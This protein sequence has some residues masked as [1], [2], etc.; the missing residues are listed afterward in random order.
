MYNNS[1]DGS[2][3][4]VGKSTNPFDSFSDDDDSCV[5]QEC[6]ETEASE[7]AEEESL[8]SE[9]TTSTFLESALFD[10][11]SQTRSIGTHKSDFS[12]KRVAPLDFDNAM[13]NQVLERPALDF[14]SA[15]HSLHASD[16]ISPLETAMT[17]QVEHLKSAVDN[18]DSGGEEC[19]EDDEAKKLVPNPSTEKS[20][21]DGGYLSRLR[22]I[23][24]YFGAS[25]TQDNSDNNTVNK[26]NLIMEG[27]H[28]NE[29]ASP[30]RALSNAEAN[31]F[32]C[33]KFP[34][35]PSEQL[36]P[37]L[38]IP[39]NINNANKEET[40]L[41]EVE[42]VL[43]R[44]NIVEEALKEN[45]NKRTLKARHRKIEGLQD[46]R[47]VLKTIESRPKDSDLTMDHRHSASPWKRLIILEELGTASSWIILL[48]PYLAF[49]LAIILDA[50]TSAWE[51]TSSNMRTKALCSDLM[52]D[53]RGT[54]YAFPVS[55]LFGPCSYVYEFQEFKGEGNLLSKFR[56]D[57]NDLDAAFRHDM[58]KGVAFSSGPMT[59]PVL[60]TFLYGDVNYLSLS[61]ESINLV[62]SG[63]VH[64]STV[65]LQQRFVGDPKQDTEWFPVSRSNSTALAMR[66]SQNNSSSVYSSLRWSC[67]SSR[68]IDLLFSV[69]E[70][71]MLT[72]GNIRVETIL[73]LADNEK[74]QKSLINSINLAQSTVNST[75]NSKHLDDQGTLSKSNKDALDDLLME[76]AQSASYEFTRSSDLRATVLISVRICC[77]LLTVIFIC[78]WFWCMGVDGFF[79][80]GNVSLHNCFRTSYV[81]EEESTLLRQ[82]KEVLWWQCPWIL[83]PER[84]Y[85]L[86][87]LLSLVLLQN[88]LLPYMYFH[89]SLYSSTKMRIIVDSLV[90]IGFHSILCLWLC[91]LEGLRYHT[92]KSARKRADHQKQ[93][94]ELRRATNFL[95]SSGVSKYSSIES[96]STHLNSYFDEFGDLHNA[97]P[98]AWT[99]LRLE[100]DMCGDGWAD[101]LL[102]KLFVFFLG[103]CAVIM[104][105][106]SRFSYFMMHG[107]SMV[108]G[109]LERF[110]I[111][112]SFLMK[113]HRVFVFSS[114]VQIAILGLWAVLI[115]RAAL[116][117]GKLLRKEPF[118]STRPAQLAY[119]VLMSI[120]VLGVTSLLL[121]IFTDEYSTASPGANFHRDIQPS[122]EYYFNEEMKSLHSMLMIIVQ[123][124][125]QRFP[126]SGTAASLGPGEIIY[127]TVATLVVAFIFLPS[128]SFIRDEDNNPIVINADGV[129]EENQRRD[130]R[131]VLTM[132]KYTHTW[133][134]FPMAIERHKHMKTS[135]VKSVK[136][137]QL[138]NKFRHIHTNIGR[139]T[140]YERNYIP[141][142]CVETALWLAECSWQTC[143]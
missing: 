23:S 121:P 29:E 82:K 35:S 58:A 61:S 67:S 106:L 83:F 100:H 7:Q 38:S 122:S 111:D 133:R 107:T 15:Q 94:L 102:P 96:P 9:V 117:T 18:D 3:R 91:L 70:I 130:K 137:Y 72:S 78:F 32:Q 140:I 39:G 118:L 48:L 97:G 110:S 41:A 139:G 64:F 73:S 85:L 10:D 75:V 114:V 46:N 22:G 119:R 126:Y 12:K 138:D 74:F 129:P 84:R 43:K 26:D 8:F 141:L 40:P 62:S 135:K 36:L 27:Y 79:F 33:T 134:A 19:N 53:Q 25:E 105:S 76:I 63:L 52:G 60:S 87:L 103:A 113:H 88:P 42:D 71:S 11:V 115:I 131:D 45:T 24:S 50:N 127:C 66:C 77:L 143:K 108:D 112:A 47:N 54:F 2:S 30:R 80:F 5:Y 6:N 99:N 90:G 51:T 92:A 89:P 128:T 86:L 93:I 44:M 20:V 16:F 34:G 123:N 136:G 69:P 65:V 37:L 55:P 21:I 56:R 17:N 125:M 4:E 120:L 132:S 81:S 95:A 1:A 14:D 57:V 98:S 49:F 59:V 13:I 31:S 101:F 116:K 68:N 142:Y 28:E 109:V 104:S 124:A